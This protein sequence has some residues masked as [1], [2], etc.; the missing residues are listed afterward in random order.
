ML[1]CLFVRLK[2]QNKVVNLG[3]GDSKRLWTKSAGS[4][5]CV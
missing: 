2:S 3:V 1:F 4:V 5:G